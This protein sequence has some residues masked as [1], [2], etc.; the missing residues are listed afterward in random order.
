[1][2]NYCTYAEIKTAMPDSQLVQMGT[3]QHENAFNALIT[4]ASRLIDKEVGRWQ[5]YF[6][7]T[8]DG[9]ARYYDGSGN[10]ELWIDEC[11]SVTSLGVAES[12][13]TCSTGYTT[14]TSTEY[15]AWPYNYSALSQ[16]ILRLDIDVNGDKG[17]WTRFRKA[18]KLTG[19]FGYSSTPPEDIKQA[20]IIQVVRWYM[21]AKQAFQDAGASVELGQ[22]V[23]V[24]QLD[25]DIR[26]LL[27][28]YKIAGMVS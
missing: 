26:E 27:H 20:C 24:Q 15:Q 18:I 13:E 25:P 11:L 8:T 17:T 22:M 9:E 3:T 4:R 12:G 10:D 7:P 14:W 1:M 5:N 28:A 2:A 19:V 16:P 23:Y 6:Y 21:R